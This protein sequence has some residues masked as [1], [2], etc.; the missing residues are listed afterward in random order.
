MKKIKSS[1]HANPLASLTP[2]QW[3][4][5]CDGCGRCCL[6]K[7]EN[8]KT[9]KV[10]FTAAAC[11][12]LDLTTCRC[13]DYPNRIEKVPECLVL[14]PENIYG[15]W[16]PRSCAYRRIAEGKQLAWWHPLVSGDPDTVRQAGISVSELA[17]CERF[18]H[19]DSLEDYILKDNPF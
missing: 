5:L 9:G 18:I 11:Q 15:R 2:D 19:P 17:I 8:K 3:E 1:R 16:L 10:Y 6:I 7:L 4:R 13:T 14:T 12:L